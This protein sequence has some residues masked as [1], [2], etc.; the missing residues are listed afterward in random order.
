MKQRLK[1]IKLTIFFV[2]QFLLEMKQSSY[3]ET[4]TETVAETINPHVKLFHSFIFSV[5]AIFFTA[6]FVSATFAQVQ[7]YGVD[8]QIDDKQKSSVQLTITFSQPEKDFNFTV[9]GS[10]Q[11]FSVNSTAGPQNCILQVSVLTVINCKLNL[12]QD[13]RTII[14]NFDTFDFIKDLNGRFLFNSDFSLN[15]EIEQMT[16]SIR[17]PEGKALVGETVPNRIS[18][19]DK[20]N[21]LSDGRHIIVEWRLS[22]VQVDDPLKFQVLYENI[23]LQ[24]LFDF[25]IRYLLIAG[26]VIG[27]ASA[28]IYLRYFRKPEKVI[29][30][31]LDEYERKIFDIIV[32]AGGTINQRKVVQETNLS[33]AKVSRVVKSLVNRGVIEVERLGRTNKLKILKKKFMM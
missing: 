31:V 11:K 5:F 2:K 12:T 32:A 25:R 13:Q 7:F 6:F 30:S 1:S 8:V 19:P 14:L 15:R 26:A 29:L 28:F 18:F 24:P 23:I 4:V 22:R 21:I 16:V 3:V 9:V 10:I 20:A 33:K 17:L 27:V